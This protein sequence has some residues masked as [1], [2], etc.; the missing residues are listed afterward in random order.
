MRVEHTRNTEQRRRH[1]SAHRH[2]YTKMQTQTCTRRPSHMQ[3]CVRNP[4][5][6]A[7]PSTYAHSRARTRTIHAFLS[8]SVQQG[9]IWVRTHMQSHEHIQV[10]ARVH[11]D[12][13]TQ[14]GA[15]TR[16]H[17]PR[18]RTQFPAR[19]SPPLPLRRR[20]GGKRDEGRA[21][22]GSQ[23][24]PPPQACD[25][26]ILPPF[27]PHQPRPLTLPIHH[28]NEV[29]LDAFSGSARGL[30]GAHLALHRCGDDHNNG[31]LFG[32]DGDEPP[33]RGCRAA[34][35][36]LE[37]LQSAVTSCKERG[38]ASHADTA[39][40]P[41]RGGAALEEVAHGRSQSWKGRDSCAD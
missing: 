4:H 8:T 40:T 3:V 1:L 41:S 14:A 15:H 27:N 13:P 32:S 7:F 39:V 22:E 26:L 31:D 18:T 30:P 33:V 17:T 19:H 35:Q 25:Y 29:Y 34:R 12:P 38:G 6:H 21:G 20:G 37:P 10:H 36:Q 11:T 16:V 28:P 23:S 24:P 5:R 2:A 9:H